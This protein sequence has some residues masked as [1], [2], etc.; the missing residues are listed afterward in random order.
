[1]YDGEERSVFTRSKQF[2]RRIC[3]L[4]VNETAFETSLLTVKRF[5][6][7]AVAGKTQNVLFRKDQSFLFLFVFAPEAL[8]V[9][10]SQFFHE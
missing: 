4:L 8:Q 2:N 6:L 1:M 5:I 10:N 7:S 3:V 9:E